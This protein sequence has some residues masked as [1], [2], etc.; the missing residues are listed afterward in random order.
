MAFVLMKIFE[1]SP[2][3][4][5][6]LMHIL[7]FGQLQEIRDQI[8]S[9]LVTAGTE[10]LEIGCG[11]GALVEQLASHGTRVIGIDAAQKMVDE[12]IRKL[13]K[14]QLEGRA[15]VRKLHALQI[16]DE[17]ERHSFDRVVSVLAFS[18]M[19]DD[20]VDCLLRQCHYVLRPGG[21]FVL[22]DEV[23]PQGLFR[24]AIY[25]VYRYFA[26]LVTFLGLQAVELTQ[27]R[28]HLKILYFAIELPLMLLT[29]LVVPPVTHPLANIENRVESAGFRLLGSENYL[30]GSLRLLHVQA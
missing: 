2:R 15:E 4:F 19:S 12:A 18:E 29:F 24:R 30:G 26:R 7:S 27:A 23:E 22:V 3:R 20:E 13:D 8:T 17:F 6:R 16:E 14:A 10:V 1:E 5:D 9:K 11:T 25:R 28:L 21:Q